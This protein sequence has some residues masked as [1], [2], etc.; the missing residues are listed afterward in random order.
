MMKMTLTMMM[1]MMMIMKDDVMTMM[2]SIQLINIHT[3][4]KRHVL[5]AQKARA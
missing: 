5:M 4:S 3:W 2:S 1:V